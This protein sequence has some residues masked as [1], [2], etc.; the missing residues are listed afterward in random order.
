M[1]LSPI[2]NEIWFTLT[3]KLRISILKSQMFKRTLFV[4]QMQK[5]L[6]RRHHTPTIFTFDLTIYILL[7][8]NSCLIH[9]KRSIFF[10]F[11]LTFLKNT[12]QRFQ[13]CYCLFTILYFQVQHIH[14]FLMLFLEGLFILSL[15]NHVICLGTVL[16]IFLFHSFQSLQ[17]FSQH[18]VLWFE[19]LLFKNWSR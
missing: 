19:K 8:L 2:P 6:A 7:L 3:N 9:T 11:W 18:W 4:L 13:L 15:S 12:N 10:T 17:L 14:G 16:I 1:D 5:V